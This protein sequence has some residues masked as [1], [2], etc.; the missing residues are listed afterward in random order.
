MIKR[1]IVF[2]NLLIF[3]KF[4]QVYASKRQK[5]KNTAR[6]KDRKTERQQDRKTERQVYATKFKCFNNFF[7]SI[8]LCGG[9]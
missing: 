2:A 6:Q 5:D 4:M 9:A 8:P 1:R 3:R 7:N